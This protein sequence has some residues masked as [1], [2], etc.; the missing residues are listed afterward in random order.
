MARVARPLLSAI[1]CG[2][3]VLGAAGCGQTVPGAARPAGSGSTF[4]VNFDKLLRECDVVSPTEI[5]KALG[6]GYQAVSSFVGAVCMWNVGSAMVT[7]NWY[8]NGSLSVERQTI[9]KLGYSATNV[10]VAGSQAMEIRRPNDADS[11]GLTASA[12]DTGVIGWWINYRPGTSH[13][14]PCAAGRQLLEQ[15]LNLAR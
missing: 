13:S 14:D 3:L 10:T 4:N 2:A 8:E 11:C 15:T 9:N 1:A 12:A 7:L 6:G 5:A